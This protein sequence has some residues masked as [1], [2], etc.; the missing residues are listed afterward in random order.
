MR[1]SLDTLIKRSNRNMAKG[2]KE[3][4]RKNALEM[5]KKSY[6]EGINVQISE[7]YRSNKR[8]NELYAQGR[9]KPGKI[10]T[11]AKAGQSNHNYGIAVDYFLVSNDGKKALWT[12]NKKWRRVAQIGKNLGFTWG[13]DWNSFKDYPHLEMKELKNSS[14]GSSSSKNKGGKRVVKKINVDGYM[15]KKTIKRLQQFFGTP[16]DGKLSKPSLVIKKLQ[17][18][19]NENGQ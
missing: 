13:G 5:I 18:F 2:T 8:Q 11:N 15:G 10:V 19:L 3:Q 16:Q 9:T 4:V 6:N 17:K 12:V 7:G 1:V 14:S